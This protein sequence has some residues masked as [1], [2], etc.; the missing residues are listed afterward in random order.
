M[1]IVLGVDSVEP[2]D[3]S[4]VAGVLLVRA[5]SPMPVAVGLLLIGVGAVIWLAASDGLDRRM[6]S[7]VLPRQFALYPLVAG[8]ALLAMAAMRWLLP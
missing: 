2:G 5:G 6:P 1:L 3:A 7:Q 8:A 4:G